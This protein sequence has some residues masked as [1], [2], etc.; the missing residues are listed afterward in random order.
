MEVVK[1]VDPGIHK[2]LAVLLSLRAALIRLD[3]RVKVDCILSFVFGN[4]KKEKLREI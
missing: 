3:R 4:V 1:A 2:N